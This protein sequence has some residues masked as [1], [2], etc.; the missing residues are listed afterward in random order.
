VA[1]DYTVN[2]SDDS[3]LVPVHAHNNF[4][5]Y[6]D[7]SGIDGAQKYVGFGSLW[8]PYE[9]RGR[10]TGLVNRQRL[11][12][13]FN[14][15]IKWTGVNRSNAKFYTSLVQEFF[16]TEWL[17]FHAIVVRKAVI[18]R[19]RHASKEEALMK[20]FANFL[21]HKIQTSAK[22]SPNRHYYVREPS[23]AEHHPGDREAPGLAG[24]KC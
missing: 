20:F 18:D 6:C 2:L 5:V 12:H 11:A 9:A 10:F 15:E 1:R 23:Q 22:R 8:L 17:A 4:L 14:D 21:A 13:G 16:R 3:D 7:E 19:K 24:P